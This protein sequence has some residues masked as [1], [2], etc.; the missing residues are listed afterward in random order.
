[1]A[2]DRRLIGALVVDA[3]DWLSLG[4][5]ISVL[6]ANDHVDSHSQAFFRF[7]IPCAGKRN[8][9]PWISGDGHPN[10]V[11]TAND[12]IGGIE[13]NPAGAGEI[14]LTPGMGRPTT[15]HSHTAGVGHVYR[16]QTGPRF[17]A[18]G[19]LLST[20]EKRCISGPE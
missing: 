18:R 11:V 19:G 2:P 6:A 4:R 20:P 17:P 1:V 13:L 7:S 15:S 14:Y 16:R 5:S 3:S 10:Q 9:L 12:A 8:S